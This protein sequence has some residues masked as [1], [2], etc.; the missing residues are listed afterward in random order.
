LNK[1]KQSEGFLP[2]HDKTDAEVIYNTLGMSKKTFK[3]TIGNLYRKRM[4]SIEPDGIRLIPK[5]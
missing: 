3:M 2:Y 4:I 5:K 1:L